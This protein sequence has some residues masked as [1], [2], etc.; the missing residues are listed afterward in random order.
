MIEQALHRLTIVTC[1]PGR[2]ACADGGVP[3]GDGAD[4]LAGAPVATPADLAAM[5]DLHPGE[6][7]WLA[8]RRGL[9]RRVRDV[10]LRN[11]RYRWL[12]RVRRRRA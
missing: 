3:A 5:L 10:R 7:A 8:D 1:S 2:S 4:A 11:Y 6:L 9:E 12:P